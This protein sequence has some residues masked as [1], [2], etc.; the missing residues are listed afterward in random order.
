MESSRT[1]NTPAAPKPLVEFVANVQRAMIA[2]GWK[3]DPPAVTV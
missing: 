3:I 2:A 1:A